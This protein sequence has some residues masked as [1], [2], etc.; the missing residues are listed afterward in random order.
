M[1]VLSGLVT[2]LCQILYSDQDVSWRRVV[3]SPA[4]FLGGV[5]L[6][7]DVGGVVG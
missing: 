1:R 4:R 6:S 5:L 7:S 2:R 3:A